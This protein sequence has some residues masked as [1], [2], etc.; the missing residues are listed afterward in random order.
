L[1]LIDPLWRRSLTYLPTLTVS[2]T[3]VAPINAERR[4]MPTERIVPNE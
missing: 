2:D 1:A 3:A 4:S